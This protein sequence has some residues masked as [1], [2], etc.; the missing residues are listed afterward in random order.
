MKARTFVR[1]AMAGTLATIAAAAV[2]AGTATAAPATVDI[3]EAVAQLRV[4]AQGDTDATAAISRLADAPRTD[5][6]DASGTLSDIGKVLPPTTV[7]V[8]LF[9]VPAYSDT[10][11]GGPV[12][13]Q[14]YGTGLATNTNGEFRFGFFGGPGM[15]SRNQ[16]GV[17]LSVV[18]LNLSNGTSGDPAGERAREGRPDRHLVRADPGRSARRHARRRDLRQPPPRPSRRGDRRQHDLVAVAGHRPL[19]TGLPV[20]LPLPV[21]PRGRSHGHGEQER[22]VLEGLHAVPRGRQHDQITRRALPDVVAGDELESPVEDDESRL[23]GAVVLRQLL[24]RRQRDD[25]LTQ[26]PA[27]AAEDRGRAASARRRASQFRLLAGERGQR[28]L[29]HGP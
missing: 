11:Q 27:M 6:G 22:R 25:R 23:A 15:I 5:L 17:G 14:L 10:G 28:Q 21:P 8:Q 4:A 1:R 12:L 3:D 2:F 24:A 20:T 7:P 29:V 9:P 26:T 16:E 18:Y 19:L 13:G